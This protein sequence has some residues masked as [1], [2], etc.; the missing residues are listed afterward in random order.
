MKCL[1]AYVY[2]H[3]SHSSERS[4]FP[5]AT[6]VVVLHV[7]GGNEDA[8]APGT[9]NVV[10]LDSRASHGEP[11]PIFV[12]AVWTA[13]SGW[14]KHPHQF[15]FGGRYIASNDSRFA[16]MVTEARGHRFYGAV[17]LHDHDLT[18]EQEM[19]AGRQADLAGAG[20]R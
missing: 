9:P 4:P 13:E 16:L 7:P 2:S 8:P 1:D 11:S 18:V 15:M 6:S 3:P 14:V 10:I 17:P 19:A 20:H 5:D 12:P